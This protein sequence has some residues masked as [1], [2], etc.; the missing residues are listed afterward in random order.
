MLP[1]YTDRPSAAP[2]SQISVHMA[3]D[4]AAISVVRLHHGN[5]DPRGPGLLSDEVADLGVATPGAAPDVV[6][7]SYATA[8]VLEAPRRE[9][10]V[11]IDAWFDNLHGGNVLLT[12]PA[13]GAVTVAGGHGLRWEDDDRRSPVHPV[14][15]RCWTR[16]SVTITSS[17]AT[18]TTRELS[19]GPGAP[20]ESSVPRSRSRQPQTILLAATS[21]PPVHGG[22]D[23]KTTLPIVDMDGAPAARYA[24]DL[25][26]PQPELL[27]NLVSSR[28]GP[29]S[30]HNGPVFGVTD[31]DWTG[32]AAGFVDGGRGHQAIRFHTDDLLDCGWPAAGTWTVPDDAPSGVYAFR[33][34]TARGATDLV[35]FAVTPG[36]GRNPVTLLLPTFTYL[37][38]ANER[39]GPEMVPDRPTTLRYEPD[40][41]DQWLARHPQY[42]RSLY[43]KHDDGTG[44]HHSGWRRPIPNMRPDYRCEFVRGARHFGADLYLV[45]WLEQEGIAFDVITDHDLDADGEAALSGTGVLITGTHPEYVSE[46]ILKAIDGHL[47]GGGTA[48][49]LG[50]NGFYWVCERLHGTDAVEVRRG[51]AGVRAWDS[52]AGETTM[53][54]GQPGGLWLHRRRSSFDLFGAGFVAQGWDDDPVGYALHD[55]PSPFEQLTAGV[56]REFGVGGLNIGG[57]AGDE[58]DATHPAHSRP[59]SVVIAT[60]T[61][62]SDYYHPSC[63]WIPE[64]VHGLS[65]R[66]NPAIR[67]EIVITTDGGQLRTFAVG[68]IAWA[69]CLSHNGYDNG[70]AT[71]TR[72]AVALLLATSAELV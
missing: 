34:T 11:T 68:S 37:A 59:G 24:V 30:L 63:E 49:Y 42:G 48:M 38:Y 9:L 8:T 61:G 27:P 13:A 23:A 26:G 35:P 28:V 57:A 62:H 31:P 15:E 70:V 71:L 56:P 55:V 14:R 67:S 20:I 43:D 32:C 53:L 33:L 25:P 21:G 72:N 39:L 51:H 1:A 29:L 46:S 18:M 65:G 54:N 12:L 58:L 66:S 60:S 4:G 41:R 69:S 6:T 22:L 50:G 36:R 5:T 7:G 47:A 45:H 19:P 2:G 3:G 10:T 52:A 64:H 40:P 44:V 17:T 16:V